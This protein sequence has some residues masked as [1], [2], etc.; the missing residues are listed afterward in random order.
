M[1]QGGDGEGRGGSKKSKSI[2]APPCG[3]GLKSCPI[4]TSPHLQGGE[5]LCGVKREEA[6]QNCHP[7]F[8]V[9]Q[10][11][12]TIPIESNLLFFFLTMEFRTIHY[13]EN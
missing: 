2:P 13:L 6:G 12:K 11:V 9:R 10:N 4:L 5:N 8:Y 7:K 1:G 3:E